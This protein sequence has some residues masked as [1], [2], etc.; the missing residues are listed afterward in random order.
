LGEYDEERNDAV[1][2]T[3]GMRSRGLWWLAALAAVVVSVPGTAAHSAAADEELMEPNAVWVVDAF[4][5]GTPLDKPEDNRLRGYGFAASIEG[6]SEALMVERVFGDYKPAPGQKI[7]VFAVKFDRYG[8]RDHDRP[9]R[10]TVVVDGRRTAVE[11]PFNSDGPLIAASVPVDAVD[12]Q[13]ELAAAELAQTFSLTQRKRVGRQPVALYRDPAAPE[14]VSDVNADRL[15]KAADDRVTASVSV[16]LKRVRLSW[17]SPPEPVTTP[18]STDRAYL[19]AEAEAEAEPGGS[20]GEGSFEDFA[21]VPASD[22]KL[23]LSPDG[24]RD[25]PAASSYLPF[26]HI[27]KWFTNPER[28]RVQWTHSCRTTGSISPSPGDS[29]ASSYWWEPSFGLTT[30]WLA[31]ATRSPAR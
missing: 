24:A 8:P 17:F 26:T 31:L 20:T 30:G 11:F 2:R 14:V 16:T 19:V 13:F 4:V 6:V 5:P 15:V 1:K 22:V 10:G 7:L 27:R 25:C 18:A 28:N 29:R 12:V 21:T 3:S 9:V 23:R